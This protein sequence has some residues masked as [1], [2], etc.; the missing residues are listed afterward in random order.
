MAGGDLGLDPVDAG[1]GE[2][3]E[4]RQALVD[5]R[6]IPPGAVLVLQYDEIAG[7]VGPRLAPGVLQQ[8]QREQAPGLGRVGDQV[9]EQPGEADRLGA[10]VGAEELPLG[11]LV[12]LVEDEVDHG[13]HAVEPLGQRLARRHAIGDRRVFDLALRAGEPLPER[14]LGHEERPRDLAGR[15]TGDRPQGE[16]HLG[17]EGERRVAAGEQEPQ[18]IVRDL[19]HVVSHRLQ[20]G[21]LRRSRGLLAPHLL[22]AQPVDRTVPRRREEPGG[23]VVGH[24]AL[25]PGPKRLLARLVPGLL[26]Q[27][28][29]VR[30]A[31]QGRDGASRVVAVGPLDGCIDGGH[32]PSMTGRTSI[33][34]VRAPGIRDAASM[35]AS[36][37]STS[38]RK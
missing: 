24:A 17:L 10:Q 2:R 9:V 13:A 21:D 34:P 23:R 29:V 12:P 27:V 32:P 1:L 14:R 20:L 3:L 15:E 18:P 7:G 25:R 5:H 16:R 30:H 31:D 37:S 19:M 26:G 35:A 33:E 4:Q 22:P 38:T 36:R 8:H 11:R 6:V 28:E